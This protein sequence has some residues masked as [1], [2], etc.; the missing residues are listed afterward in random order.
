MFRVFSE[1]LGFRFE[2]ILPDHPA[3]SVWMNEVL[4]YHVFDAA[5]DAFHGVLFLDLFPREGKYAH[6]ACWNLVPRLQGPEGTQPCVT[7]VLGNFSRELLPFDEVETL[8]H[9]IGHAMHNLSATVA[10]SSLVSTE[11][12]FVEAPS[13]VIVILLLGFQSFFLILSL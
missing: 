8:F 7:A 9:E 10:Y 11:R 5:S 12:D 4:Q 2:A 13:Q 1:F 6:A 3:R